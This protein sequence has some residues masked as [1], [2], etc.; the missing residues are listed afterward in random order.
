MSNRGCSICRNS[1]YVQSRLHNMEMLYHH[2]H[3]HKSFG[4]NMNPSMLVY[5]VIKVATWENRIYNIPVILK[6]LF[7]SLTRRTLAMIQQ[8]LYQLKTNHFF[9][10]FLKP[11]PLFFFFL[12]FCNNLVHI[13]NPNCTIFSLS[14]IL[15]CRS[16]S[17]EAH[18]LAYTRFFHG[19]IITRSL[20]FHISFYLLKERL[21]SQLSPLF[22]NLFM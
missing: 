6:C 10:S 1:L 12:L 21:Q 15:D 13:L 14:C 22:L 16:I 17:W 19:C 7:R 2:I 20:V 18:L 9:I 3:I 5:H 8:Y 4:N 11:C